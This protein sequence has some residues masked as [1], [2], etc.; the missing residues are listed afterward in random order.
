[1]GNDIGTIDPGPR[2]LSDRELRVIRGK[3]RAGAATIPEVMSVFEHYDLIE[4]NL[5]VLDT[6]EVF[7]E[8]ENFRKGWRVAFG[9]PE[10]GKS[11]DKETPCFLTPEGVV[12]LEVQKQMG[13]HVYGGGF[14]GAISNTNWEKFEKSLGLLG[15]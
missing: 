13:E 2:L 8:D 9:I 7:R 4:K 10:N 12:E 5:D 15:E 3:V 1:M 6:W 14:E 11:S